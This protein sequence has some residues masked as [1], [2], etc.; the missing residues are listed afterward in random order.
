MEHRKELVE[1]VMEAAA[2]YELWAPHD[3]IV[4]AVSG[5]PDSVALLRVLHEISLTRMPLTLICA[6]VNHGFRAESA[7]EAELVR[8]L[9]QAWN[10]LRAGRIRYSVHHQGERARPGRGCT[11]EALPVP[12]RYRTPLPC[13]LCCAGPSCRRSG[14]DG[15]HAAAAGSGPSGLAGMSWKR[16]EKKV[17]LIRPFLRINKTA[18]VGF[19]REE[20]LAYAEDATNLL[21]KYQA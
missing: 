17:E 4:V 12:D 7:E 5:G 2:E 13:A 11:G 8:A 1:S 3:T 20:G 14:R 15:A 6:H 9:A 10:P 16:T 19:C 18:L 21:T